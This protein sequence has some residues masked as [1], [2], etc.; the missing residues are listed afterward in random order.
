MP[1]R[2]KKLNHLFQRRKKSSDTTTINPVTPP[3]PP[4]DDLIDA[5]RGLHP[6]PIKR[7]V[8]RP[9]W[10][11]SV[12]DGQDHWI[13]ARQVIQLHGVDPR[14]C[15]IIDKRDPSSSMG[16]SP[17]YLARLLELKPMKSFYSPIGP[18]ERRAYPIDDTDHR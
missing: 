2:H 13:T 18:A 14:E 17:E 1:D 12:N 6:R 7:F 15:I 8:I 4:C 5:L 11:T 9:G 10:V 16:Y 3:T